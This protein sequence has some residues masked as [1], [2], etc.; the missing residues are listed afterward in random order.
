M[1]DYEYGPGGE[2]QLQ[3]VSIQE[4]SWLLKKRTTHTCTGT[5]RYIHVYLFEEEEDC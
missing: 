5:G 4:K 3:Y 1:K 2:A